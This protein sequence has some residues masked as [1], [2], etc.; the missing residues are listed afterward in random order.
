MQQRTTAAYISLAPSDA[1][2]LG[3]NHGDSVSVGDNGALAAACIRSHIKPGTAAL[4]GG[5]DV[6]VYALADVVSL[7]KAAGESNSRSIEGLI[8]SDLHE[9]GY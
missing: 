6:D 2:Q 1:Q 7:A 9:E 5:D 3:I 4:Y 8:I